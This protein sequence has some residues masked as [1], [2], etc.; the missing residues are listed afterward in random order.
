[1]DT[2]QFLARLDTVFE[3]DPQT[4]D[5]TDPRWAELAG[6][7][8][9]FTS[10]NELA[11]LN[12]AAQMLPP[13][14]VYLEVGTFKGRSLCGAVQDAGST[15]FY[16]IENY[17]EFGMLGQEARNELTANLARWGA[18]AD[19]RLVEADCFRAMARPGIVDRP[20]GVYFYDG[21]HTFLNHWLALGVAEPLLAD[22]ALVLVDDATWRVVQQAHRWYLRSRPH[23]EVVRRWDA[24]VTDDPRWANGLHALV[25]R[26]PAG[27][28][29]TMDRSVRLLRRV[30]LHVFAPL[31]K[32]QWTVLQKT[33]YRFPRVIPWIKRLVPKRSRSVR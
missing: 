4:S 17:L 8:N 29:R 2:Q 7:I 27:A 15:T 25:Y 9:G 23:W 6:S 28:A 19:V 3:G 22:E 11:V 31:E 32:L 12:L 13:D 14:E 30:Q 33:A 1:M 21:A 10:P 26:R 20:V 5:P 18:G 16:A 24:D